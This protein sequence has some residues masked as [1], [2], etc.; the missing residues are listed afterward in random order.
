M[1]TYSFFFRCVVSETG[2][3]FVYDKEEEEE[4]L[5]MQEEQNT[6]QIHQGETVQVNKGKSFREILN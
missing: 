4:D 3:A 2:H 5:I 1:H 6:I